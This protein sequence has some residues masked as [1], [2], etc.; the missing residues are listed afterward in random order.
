[1]NS[2]QPPSLESL[3]HQNEFIGRHIGPDAEDIDSML[4][5]LGLDSLERLVEKTVPAAIALGQPLNLPAAMNE[6]SALA[7]LKQLAGKNRNSRSF[8]GLGYYD[9]LTPNVILRNLLEN[10][11]WYTAYTPYQPEVS[12]GRLE[13]LLNYQQMV[14]DLTGMELANASLLDEATAAAEGMALAKRVSKNRGANKFYVDAA[15]FPQTIDVL[16]TRATFWL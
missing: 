8:I 13:S 3:Q 15:C 2:N 9:T 1:M 14:L 6:E 5:E 12:Q 16:K 10:P 4:H 11:G 7:A